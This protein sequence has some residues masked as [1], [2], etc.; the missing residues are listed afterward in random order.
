MTY[1]IIQTVNPEPENMLPID[2][3]W[4]GYL[5]RGH[6]HVL[7]GSPGS[8]KTQ[9]AIN[10]AATIGQPGRLYPCGRPNPEA[11]STMMWSGED[12]LTDTLIPRLIGA[13]CDLSK[14][15]YIS[16]VLTFNPEID[17]ESVRVPFN[18]AIH[19]EAIKLK[20]KVMDNVKLLIID[21]IASMIT[22]DGNSNP[23][24]RANLNPLVQLA[25]EFNIAILGIHHLTKGSADRPLHERVSG[26]IALSALP[27]IVMFASQD[28]RENAPN[29]YVFGKVKANITTSNDGFSYDIKPIMVS[30]SKCSIETTVISWGKELDIPLHEVLN[31]SKSSNQI[32]PSLS[33]IQQAADLILVS[34]KKE[35]MSWLFLSSICEEH[36]ISGRTA[37]TARDRLR[38]GNLI[39]IE[40]GKE[41]GRIAKWKLK[42]ILSTPPE[43]TSPLTIYANYATNDCLL[44]NIGIT[45]NNNK[46]NIESI[47]SIKS[48]GGDGVIYSA[49]SPD[50]LIYNEPFVDSDDN[51]E[52]H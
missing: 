39:E 52:G 30:N 21:P 49:K 36:K 18:P 28:P 13:G 3:V 29:K 17:D 47:I 12:S 1:E 41:W 32:A 43:D 16:D 31:A 40:Y 11:G 20:L 24:V 48:K 22:G 10:L 4:P 50:S 37:Q 34:L 35:P 8:G 2:W 6:L 15:H 38:S 46:V 5:A 45:N 27:R 23:Q 42:T 44:N 9:L 7:A 25:H 26:S 51:K 14:F 33:K 19:L